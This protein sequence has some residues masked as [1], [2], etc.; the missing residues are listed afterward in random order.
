MQSRLTRRVAQKLAIAHR[1]MS[2]RQ[3]A[4]LYGIV[5]E[6]G[7]PNPG[8]VKH[9]IDGYQPRRPDTL[10]RC[11]LLRAPRPRMLPEEPT[12]RVL[13]GAWKRGRRWVSPEEYFGARP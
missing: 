9:L 2:F 1:S 5:T 4:K 12:R 7:K 13:I 6:S 11:G 8:L 3:V 10:R